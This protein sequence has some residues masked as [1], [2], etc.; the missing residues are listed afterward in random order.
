MIVKPHVFSGLLNK[1][2]KHT[3]DCTTMLVL[4]LPLVEMQPNNKSCSQLSCGD[5]NYALH[6]TGIYKEDQLD[7]GNHN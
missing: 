7:A 5:H 4:M 1:G 6:F 2:R 3:C